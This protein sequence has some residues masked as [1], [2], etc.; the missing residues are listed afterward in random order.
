MIGFRGNQPDISKMVSDRDPIWNNFE[1]WYKKQ[2]YSD[3]LSEDE[4][5]NLTKWIFLIFL[6]IVMYFMYNYVLK[7]NKSNKS[8][9]KKKVSARIINKSNE[10]LR[11][12]KSII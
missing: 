8:L 1:E 5:N 6:I 4:D 11:K 3:N 7:R 9:E 2:G 10:S 12:L